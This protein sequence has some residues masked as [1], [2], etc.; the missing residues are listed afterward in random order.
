MKPLQCYALFH[1]NLMFSSIEE[2]QRPEVIHSCYWPLLHLIE[3]EGVPLGIELS[4]VTLEILRQIDP[5][6][7]DRFRQLLTNGQCELIGS[8]YSQLIGPL[9]PAEVNRANQQIG[10]EL[11][12]AILGVRPQVALVNEQAWSAGLVQ[13]YLDA[14]YEAVMMEW[15]NPSSTHP[16]WS[17]STRFLPQ[18][19]RGVDG[20]SIP[21]IW[22]QSIAFQKFQRYAHQELPLDD[23]LTYLDQ[24]RGGS[25]RAFS[26][27][28]NDAEIFDFRPGRFVTEAQLS[29]DSEWDRI[30]YLFQ[31]LREQGDRLILP[32][33]VL[34]LLGE[35]GGGQILE[36][37][38]AQNP[39]PVKKQTKYN[40][41]R[42]AVSGR[43][44]LSLNS[45]CWR[46]FEAMKSSGNPVIWKELCYLWSSDF[47][48]HIT[49]D[50]WAGLQQRLEEAEQRWLPSEKKRPALKSLGPLSEARR[51]GNLLHLEAGGWRYRFNCRRGLA[52]DAA[53]APG[54]TESWIGTLH[55]GFFDRITYG[56]DY[57]TGHLVMEIPGKHK[58]TDLEPAEP[59]VRQIPEGWE[60]RGTVETPL[61][62]VHKCWTVH[63]DGGRLDLAIHLQWPEGPAGALRLGHMTLNPKRFDVDSLRFSTVNGGQEAETFPLEEAVDHLDPVSALISANQGMGLTEG[64]IDLGDAERQVR[65]SFDP[66]ASSTT[67]HLVFA[68]VGD[69]FFCRAVL[70]AQEMDDTSQAH[71]KRSGLTHRSFQLSF[72]LKKNPE[73]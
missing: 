5:E 17:G 51:E 41:T 42:W 3:E 65:L 28:G 21:L 64:W 16:E 15:D 44:D 27:Y 4:G 50:R 1:L 32:A 9:V 29:S 52:L 25:P 61:G 43:D 46:L 56:H 19:A 45:R 67:G 62:P 47:R 49:Q 38:S 6:W 73:K 26:L 24:Q 35:E 72:S 2:E 57:Y 40:V 22:N 20:E 39:V 37:G 14:G 8:G 34:D 30:S 33:Q 58:V 70:S 23:Y 11:Y 71:P 59:E 55:H 60:V 31:K 18:R 69:R 13:H 63:K 48:T 12:E 54:E 66:A 53:I 7:V 36:L 10:A 68:P